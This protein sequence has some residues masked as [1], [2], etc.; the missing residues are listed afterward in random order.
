[1]IALPPPVFSTGHMVPRINF[2]GILT[3][4]PLNIVNCGSSTRFGRLHHILGPQWLHKIVGFLQ[5]GRD[6]RST[7]TLL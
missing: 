6:V 1:M 2:S 7:K 3:N 5:N 4:Q